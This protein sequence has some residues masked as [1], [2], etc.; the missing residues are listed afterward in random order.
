M[1]SDGPR[2]WGAP[3]HA[4]VLDDTRVGPGTTLLDLGC[5]TGEFA[6]AAVARGAVLT[7]IDHDP[8]AVAEAAATVPAATFAVGDVHV[9]P[10]GPFDVVVAVQ[11]LMHVADPP[12][13]LRAAATRGVLVSVTT[14]GREEDCDV[15]AFGEALAPWLPP[16][17]PAPPDRLVDLAV[18]A[19]LA[20]PVLAEVVCPF[21]YPDE[22]ALLA[23]LFET[24]MGRHAINRAGPVA[25]REAVL[26]RCAEFAQPDGS[27]VLENRFRVLTARG[28]VSSG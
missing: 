20:G 25:V 27:Y 21:H 28:S 12:A 8:A 5:G 19:G 7:G 14:W 18:T 23:P 11:V 22:D 10:P 26:A 1:P 4:R 24:G 2:G 17:R 6:A 16:R 13:L 3:L 15:R 9:P